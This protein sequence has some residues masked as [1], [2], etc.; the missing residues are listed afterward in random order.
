MKIMSDE[1]VVI[2]DETPIIEE[3]VLPAVEPEKVE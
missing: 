2:A 3:E 1:E